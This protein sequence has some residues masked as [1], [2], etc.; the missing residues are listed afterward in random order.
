MRIR[1]PPTPRTASA[2]AIAGRQAA[3]SWR[4]SIA[5]PARAASTAAAIVGARSCSSAP[6]ASAVNSLCEQ[7][8]ST[9]NPSAVSAVQIAQQDQVEP[10]RLAEAESGVDQDPLPPDARAAMAWRQPRLELAQHLVD[11]ALVRLRDG[12]ERGRPR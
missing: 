4:R 5:A 8:A 12:F 7:A 11:A 1:R 3:T 10:G 9:G 2:S 6:V